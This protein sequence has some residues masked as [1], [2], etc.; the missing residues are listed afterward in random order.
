M[1][2]WITNSQI[3][4]PKT[5]ALWG[6]GEHRAEA[7]TAPAQLADTPEGQDFVRRAILGSES[8][9]HGIGTRVAMLVWVPDRATGAVQGI[10]SCWR[11]G[12]PPDTRPS[13]DEYLVEAK[14]L[15]PAPGV[16]IDA[17]S[18]TTFDVDAGPLVVEGLITRETP[19][20]RFGGFLRTA[21]SPIAQIRCTIFPEG[22]DEVFRID[23][24]VDDLDLAGPASA[25]IGS[26][27]KGVVLTLGERP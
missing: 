6:A 16:T 20:S 18:F 19:R 8:T 15:D 27:A 2:T 1:G 17:S 10:G 3:M 7:S 5:W 12:W 9:F 23:L 22:C 4:V 21:S 11:I 26:I 14:K 24:M 25:Q 13:R